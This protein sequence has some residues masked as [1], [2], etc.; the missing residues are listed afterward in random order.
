MYKMPARKPKT[1]SLNHMEAD[2][3]TT[4]PMPIHSAYENTNPKKNQKVISNKPVR[5]RRSE[6]MLIES[7]VPTE[8]RNADR[9]QG[10]INYVFTQNIRQ[11]SEGGSR[12]T[13]C[14]NCYT[15]KSK[16]QELRVQ[17]DPVRKIVPGK[18]Q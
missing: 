3:S 16:Y 17:L 11:V 8:S 15:T 6:R 10:E 13:Q 1:R 7:D 5:L 18:L 12:V 4:I 2:I 14:Y 9:T